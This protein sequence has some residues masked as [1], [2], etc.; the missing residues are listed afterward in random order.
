MMSTENK[1]IKKPTLSKKEI[2]RELWYRGILSYK[3][4]PIQKEM[5]DIFYNSPERSRLVWVLARQSGKTYLLCILA[6]EQAIRQPNSVI[7]MVTDTKLHAENILLPKFEEVMHD[8]PQDL[9]PEYKVKQSTF[10]FTN[11]SQIQ[12]AGT[13][14]KHFEKMRG[15]KS[16]LNLVDESGFCNDLEDVIDGVL[17][18]TTTHTGGKT[19]LASTIPTQLDHLFFKYIEKAKFK[20]TLTEKT[21]YD[22]PLM[23]PEKIEEAINEMEP[24]RFRREYLNEIVKDSN[25][26]VI[27]EFNN[28]LKKDI[29]KEWVRPP[30]FDN[31]VAMDLGG[32]DLTAVLFGYYD[33]RNAKLVIED[34][35]IMDFQKPDNNLESLTKQIINKENE[36][37]LDQQINELKRPLSRVSDINPIAI[38]EILKYSNNKLYFSTA[39]KD[40]KDSALN[41][42]RALLNSKQIIINPRCKTLIL[43]LENVRWNSA[44][45]KE[46]F[47]RSPDHGHYDAVDALK[48]FVRAVNFNKNPYPTHYGID[49]QDLFIPN[50]NKFNQGDVNEIYK[51]IF[52]IKRKK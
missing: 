31:Y 47:A 5:Y 21:I 16:H 20:K 17:F 23:T 14:N 19:V 11:G 37:W 49:R 52:N 1:E 22:N 3:C 32:K 10:Y 4:H 7:K 13:D 26:S 41:H 15:I 51:Q 12:L 44:T 6:L 39:K 40:D 36:L 27:P 35:I 33:F 46:K 43:H 34:E 2:Q 38:G 8:C 9:K 18:P 25:T 45:N 48:Y 24:E 30:F 42:M 50:V 28:N 29:V